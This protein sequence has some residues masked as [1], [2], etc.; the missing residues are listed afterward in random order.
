VCAGTGAGL[1]PETVVPAEFG[2][3]RAIDRHG[4]HRPQ[5]SGPHGRPGSPGRIKITNSPRQ[6]MVAVRVCIPD[7]LRPDMCHVHARAH[8]M[9][10][11]R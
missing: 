6:A 5:E 4:N 10:P 9:C 8:R 11:V 3:A 7:L 2:Y 1:N